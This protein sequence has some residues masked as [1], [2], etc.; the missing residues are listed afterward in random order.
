MII[1]KDRIVRK[2]LFLAD[3]TIKINPLNARKLFISNKKTVKSFLLYE[4]TPKSEQPCYQNSFNPFVVDKKTRNLLIES[5]GMNKG[6]EPVMLKTIYNNKKYDFALILDSL[7]TNHII[8]DELLETPIRIKTILKRNN[9]S[10]SLRVEIELYAFVMD[11]S[12]FNIKQLS[13]SIM[14]NNSS[15]SSTASKQ[16]HIISPDSWLIKN[17]SGTSSQYTNQLSWYKEF[18]LLPGFELKKD[19]FQINLVGSFKTRSPC[20]H[21]IVI[22]NMESSAEVEVKS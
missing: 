8:V 11:R 4:Y 16:F 3:K 2:N 6:I 18:A 19:E 14:S 13:L 21:E 12:K 17:T 10:Y 7:E 5:Y 15:Q 20:C 9:I 22:K 1:V